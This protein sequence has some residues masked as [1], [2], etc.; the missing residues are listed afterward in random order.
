MIV[1]A[2][3]SIPS[4]GIPRD[5]TLTL[6][7]HRNHQG[8]LRRQQAYKTAT[9]PLSYASYRSDTSDECGCGQSLHPESGG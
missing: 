7:A 8:I 3:S 9:L 6:V 4:Y 1:P 2:S 5:N